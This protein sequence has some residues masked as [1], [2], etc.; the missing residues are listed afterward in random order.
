MPPRWRSQH[1]EKEERRPSCDLV[2][3]SPGSAS[4][5]AIAKGAAAL[6]S[7]AS[8]FSW[9]RRGRSQGLPPVIQDGVD[10]L[11]GI[12]RRFGL[13]LD[14]TGS[15]SSSLERRRRFRYVP[16]TRAKTEGRQFPAPVVTPPLNSVFAARCPIALAAC[17]QV[18]R[19]G[20]QAARRPRDRGT[21]IPIAPLANP[22]VAD[23]WASS[24]PRACGDGA[25]G[26]DREIHGQRP[27][28]QTSG[29]PAGGGP[30]HRDSSA[31]VRFRLTS[32]RS[33]FSGP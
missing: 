31:R 28:R 33:S 24:L 25:A 22:R 12:D 21:P 16:A 8:R 4:A 14:M 17:G 2:P 27:G 15:T 10:G 6:H 19:K 1:S 13:T 7:P 30:G 20:R 32:R 5:T 3:D 18:D 26:R 9:R 11:P 29:S 23:D